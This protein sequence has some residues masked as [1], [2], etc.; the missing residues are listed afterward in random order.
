ME[1][2]TAADVKW[3][4]EKPFK[5]EHEI[6]GNRRTYAKVGDYIFACNIGSQCFLC[7][8]LMSVVGLDEVSRDQVAKHMPDSDS[9]AGFANYYESQKNKAAK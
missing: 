7:G 9:I 6:P 8:P 4:L 3:Y 2:F 1:T 5:L